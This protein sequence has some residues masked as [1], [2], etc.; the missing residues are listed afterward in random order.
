MAIQPGM[1]GMVVEDMGRALAFYRLLGLAIP[2]GQEGEAFVEV[3]TPNGYRLS[4]NKAEMVRGIDPT[5]TKPIGGPGVSLAFMCDSP[6]E[7]D[8]TFRA[9]IDSGLGAAHLEPWDAFWGMRYAV[10]RD[11]DGNSVD[12]GA[13]L[14]QA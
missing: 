6:A 13:L 9:L 10:V 11:P 8:A 1:V 14:P 4:W 3:T 5:W 7:V 2:E 12:L